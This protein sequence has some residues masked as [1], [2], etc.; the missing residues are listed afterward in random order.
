ML[1]RTVDKLTTTQVVVEGRRF[2]RDTLA[3][4]GRS[5][6][7][8]EVPYR[9]LPL[10]DPQVLD[11]SA[12]ARVARLHAELGAAMKQLRDGADRTAALALLDDWQDRL[13]ATRDAIAR[14]AGG[15]HE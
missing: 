2:R 1:V 12:I 15:G 8:W 5:R 13:T 14:T 6:G 7:A 9:L 11:A 3:E 4:V 10:D